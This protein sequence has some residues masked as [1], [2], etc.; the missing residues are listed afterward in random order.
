MPE[1]TDG[2][3]EFAVHAFTYPPGNVHGRKPLPNTSAAVE[4]ISATLAD[5]L[6]TERTLNGSTAGQLAAEIEAW[7][8]DAGPDDRLI[9]YLAGHGDALADDHFLVDADT[10]PDWIT[11]STAVSA[12]ALS[13]CL[14]QTSAD[15]VLVVIDSCY[16]G[17]AGAAIA[18]GLD[19]YFRRRNPRPGFAVQVI[20][21]AMPGEKTPDGLFA[22][23]FHRVLHSEAR[24]G[25]ND[26]FIHTPLFV[27]AIEDALEADHGGTYANSV[28]LRGPKSVRRMLPNPNHHSVPD[29]EVAFKQLAR[30]HFMRSASGLEITESGWFFTGRRAILTEIVTWMRSSVNA[31]GMLVVTGP[32]GA[33]K[34][35]VVGRLALL[36]DPATRATVLTRSGLDAADPTVPGESAI[37]LGLH[38]REKTL[39]QVSDAVTASLGLP[40]GTAIA[41]LIAS[42]R[43]HPWTLLVDAL[44]EAA[45]DVI[46]IAE[47]LRDLAEAGARV[48]VGSRPDRA[49]AAYRAATG[50]LLVALGPHHRIDLGNDDAPAREQT[51]RDIADYVALR[52]RSEPSPYLGQPNLEAVTATVGRAVAERVSPSFLYARLAAHALVSTEAPILP[53]GD[54]QRLLPDVSSTE[55]FADEVERD[56]ARI[57]DR[58]RP[59]VRTMLMALAWAEGAGFPRY[60][61]WTAAAEA[62][63]GGTYA[64]RD[65]R[66]TLRHAAWY[67]VESSEADETVYRL[68]H[69][70]LIR[71][72][73]EATRREH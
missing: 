62:I 55:G 52:L 16:S 3:T 67:L 18:A 22:E 4:A 38:A 35:A 31:G 54:W 53:T 12:D 10:D 57:P 56:L 47:F 60:P 72:F 29:V 36:A 61:I 28:Q 46:R 14:A 44:D 5:H 6:P 43:Q 48:I 15:R 68:Y 73:R 11:S 42:T 30:E 37:D 50:P 64:D 71:Y 41:D 25:P 1:R 34:S 39:E 58:V 66:D 26:R 23:T 33:G 9:L 63:T 20:T 69:E 49:K 8:R 65:V 21:S 51:R 2:A 24:W 7:L 19:A 17:E 59:R 70:E 45:G 13:L 40:I 32:P 27:E